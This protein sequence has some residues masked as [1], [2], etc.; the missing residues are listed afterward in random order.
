MPTWDNSFKIGVNLID[1]QHKTLFDAMDDLFAA[2]SQGKGRQ[3]VTK[4]LDFL[5]GYVAKHF[6]DEEVLQKACGYPKCAE[7]KQ[8][9]EDYKKQVAELKKEIQTNGPS[10]LT[11]S[12]MNSLLSGWLISH[13]KHVDTEIAQYAN[14]AK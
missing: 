11:V 1:D 12:K 2:C 4:T 5:E 9:H 6:A 13:I 3:E 10:V 8:I 14:K 7:H